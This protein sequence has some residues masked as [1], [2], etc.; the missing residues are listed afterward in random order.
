MA[1]EW[2]NDATEEEVE[3]VEEAPVFKAPSPWRSKA[4]TPS[5]T[6]TVQVE[7]IGRGT[8]SILGYTFSNENRIQSIPSDVANTVLATGKFK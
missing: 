4:S 2:E 8:Y 3:V 7:F 6:A 1:D 5:T